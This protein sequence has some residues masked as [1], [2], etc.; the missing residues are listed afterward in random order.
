[1]HDDRFAT[2]LRDRSGTAPTGKPVVAEVQDLQGG[3][4]PKLCRDGAF[5]RH[6]IPKVVGEEHTVTCEE[7]RARRESR[8]SDHTRRD[9][10]LRFSSC[11]GCF[12]VPFV[13]GM[14]LESSRADQRHRES[15][16]E[17]SY[18][19]LFDGGS[20]ARRQRRKDHSQTPPRRA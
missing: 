13:K 11:G 7:G 16:E 14:Q 9:D 1:M 6:P 19:V 18:C 20:I 8:P 15:I 17:T 5:A 3:Q 2:N 12:Y 4:T 10:E